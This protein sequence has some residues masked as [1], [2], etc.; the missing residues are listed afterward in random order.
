MGMLNT[1]P[2]VV[3]F[4]SACSLPLASGFHTWILLRNE[5]SVPTH[6]W[7]CPVTWIIAFKS[8]THLPLAGK[9]M[10]EQTLHSFQRNCS[11]SPHIGKKFPPAGKPFRFWI[12]F[13]YIFNFLTL[14]FYRYNFIQETHW[15]RI[16]CLVFSPVNK[17]WKPDFSRLIFFS[18]S[19]DGFPAQCNGCIIFHSTPRFLEMILE[20]F[21]AMVMR[22]QVSWDSAICLVFF[23]NSATH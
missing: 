14:E 1:W 2:L 9:C 11:L 7:T 19:A 12:V 15:N 18:V 5:R 16:Y 10:R 6:R 21:L 23:S 13:L 4:Q 8:N 17:Y 20:T 3:S 22:L